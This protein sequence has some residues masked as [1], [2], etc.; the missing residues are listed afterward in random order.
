MLLELKRQEAEFG[1]D[2]HLLLSDIKS[3][4]AFL[5]LYLTDDAAAE[6]A[7]NAHSQN[8]NFSSSLNKGIDTFCDGDE[9]RT[10]F[11]L[12]EGESKDSRKG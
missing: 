10:T 8:I 4:R 2:V 6:G 1:L 5:P 12:L 9:A 7:A 11:E 3:G